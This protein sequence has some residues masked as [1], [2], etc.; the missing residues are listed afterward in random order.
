MRDDQRLALSVQRYHAWPTIQTQT[1]ADHTCHVMRIYMSIWGVPRGEVCAYIVGHDMDEILTGCDIPFNQ[2][3]DRLRS[4]LA[5]IVG[6]R[7]EA[8]FPPFPGRAGLAPWERVYVK[9]CD[10]IEMW[11]FGH[12]EVRLGNQFYGQPIVNNTWEQLQNII[13]SCSDRDKTLILNY[14]EGREYE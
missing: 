7:V 4:E 11:E 8:M 14:M 1:N 9:V 6:T 5:N 13:S 3:T 12:E 10:L 2:K